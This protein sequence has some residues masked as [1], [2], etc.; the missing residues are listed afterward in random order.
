MAESIEELKEKSVLSH[1]ILTMLGSMGDITGHVMVRVPGEDAFLARCRDNH[2][3][4]PGYVEATALHRVDFDGKALDP[5]GDYLIPPERHIGAA[6]FRR[7]PEINCVIHAHPPAQVLCVNTGVEIRPIIGAQNNGGSA[8]ARGGIAVYPRSLLIH[9]KEIAAAMLAVMGDKNLVLLK[10]HGN[11]VAG[12]SVE[13]ATLR[14]L[15]IEN[16]ARI[17]WEV[18]LSGRHA[19]DVPWEDVEESL[20]RPDQGGGGATATWE[21]YK[22]LYLEGRKL[23]LASDEAAAPKA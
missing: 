18:A 4:S 19:D 1:R 17:C 22:R 20:A 13:E 14:A 5:M 9:N 10:G 16:L 2:D 3:V 23:W 15:Q 7:R 8:L 21:Y 12:R 11:V 6:I